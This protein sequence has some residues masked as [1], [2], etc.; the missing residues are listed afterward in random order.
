MENIIYL[1]VDNGVSGAIAALDGTGAIVAHSVLPLQKL[2]TGNAIDVLALRDWI[3]NVRAL[4]PEARVSALLEEPGGTKSAGAAKGMYGSFHSIR[5][6]LDLL[7]LRWAGV[8]PQR[9]QKALIPG[10]KAKETK[11]RALSRARQLWPGEKFLATDR[12]RVPHD[13]IVDALLIAEFARTTG[14]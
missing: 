8:T 6:I 11:P 9:W 2:R 14:A 3:N 7:G 12:C 10:A 5:S 13:G 1:G 4:H